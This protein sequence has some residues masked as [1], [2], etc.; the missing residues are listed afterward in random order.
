MYTNRLGYPNKKK[1]E[2]CIDVLTK[3]NTY[4]SNFCT[5]HLI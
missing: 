4:L 2:Q 1:K 3:V 5:S